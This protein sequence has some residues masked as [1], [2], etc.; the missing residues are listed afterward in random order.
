LELVDEIRLAAHVT[1]FRRNI[2]AARLAA[3]GCSTTRSMTRPHFGGSMSSAG[4]AHNVA[5]RAATTAVT[6]AS[7]RAKSGSSLR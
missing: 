1:A 3:T 5:P 7:Y 2:A 4:P 6:A